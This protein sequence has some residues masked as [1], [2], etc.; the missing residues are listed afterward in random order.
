MTPHTQMAVAGGTAVSS[1]EIAELISSLRHLDH[2]IQPAASADPELHDAYRRHTETVSIIVGHWATRILELNADRPLPPL[3]EAT[4][5]PFLDAPI[6]DDRADADEQAYRRWLA[7][8]PIT[9]STAQLEEFN[10]RL[11][12]ARRR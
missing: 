1:E 10:T 7:G 8:R 12:E 5:G 4:L 2:R 9:L 3:L 6:V 11:A